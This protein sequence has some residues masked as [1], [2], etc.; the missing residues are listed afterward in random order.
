MKTVLFGPSMARLESG[1][2][3]T[4]GLAAFG[5]FFDVVD[6][7]VLGPDVVEVDALGHA[8]N[9]AFTPRAI[10]KDGREGRPVG[11][12]FRNANTDH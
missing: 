10:G 12:F 2:F 11:S 4:T 3:F 9:L 1:A 7:T 8:L 6:S 5:G